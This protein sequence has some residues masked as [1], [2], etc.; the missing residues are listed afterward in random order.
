MNYHLIKKDDMLN[1]DGLRATVFCS[2]CD[3]HC[4]LCQNPETWDITSGKPFDE[5]AE[6]YLFELL[7]KSYIS[8]V[9]FSG[10][11]PLNGNNVHYL[12][13]L[14]SKIR[15]KYKNN[16]TIWI[17]T[18]YNYEDIKRTINNA[19]D[20]NRLNILSKIDILVDGRYVDE[21][22]DVNYPW[23]GSTNQRV[24]DVQ[25]SLKEGKI[26]LYKSE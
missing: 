8:G 14:I 11:D 17:Y 7:D 4:R 16:K 20:A 15:E 1:G 19:D 9:T 25:Q 13:N 6:K 23:A 10:G 2:G 3:H 12:A 22:K 24:I 5:T 21:L 18:G 26:V